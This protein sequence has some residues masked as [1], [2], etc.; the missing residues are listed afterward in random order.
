M[1]CDY[2]TCWDWSSSILVKGAQQ[3]RLRPTKSALWSNFVQHHGITISDI[4]VLQDRRPSDRR[5]EVRPLHVSHLEA[6]ERNCQRAPVPRSNDGAVKRREGRPLSPVPPPPDMPSTRF[7]V[8]QRNYPERHS[9]PSQRIPDSY[10]YADCPVPSL[11][12]TIHKNPHRPRVTLLGSGV[13][14]RLSELVNCLDFPTTPFQTTNPIRD[15]PFSD[16]VVVLPS[17][18][19][20]ADPGD[21]CIRT[22]GATLQA[23]ND[24]YEGVQIILCELWHLP[25]RP[26]ITDEV[27]CKVDRVN[28]F[29][30][31]MGGKYGHLKVLQPDFNNGHFHT[32]GRHLNQYGLRRLADL[33]RNCLRE[34]TSFWGQSSRNV[35]RFFDKYVNVRW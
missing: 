9:L 27:N 33:I 3:T 5:R 13:V 35:Q 24:T 23:V 34:T 22:I 19:V 14:Y 28:A 12:R 30:N 21:Y 6:S 20:F 26:H 8:R 15:M 16:V 32:H 4:H 17:V 2:F 25:E 10:P 1:A 18:D 11:A 7:D 31:F 29:M